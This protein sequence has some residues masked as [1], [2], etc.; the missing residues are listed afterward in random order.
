MSFLIPAPHELHIPTEAAPLACHLS[1]D[2]QSKHGFGIHN[3]CCI[4]EK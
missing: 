3:G 1:K 2:R 4:G